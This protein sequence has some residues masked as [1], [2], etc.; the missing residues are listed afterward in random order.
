MEEKECRIETKVFAPDSELCDENLC[1][2]CKDGVW[3]EKGT[4]DFIVRP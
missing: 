3:Q 2:V 4:L 1:Y